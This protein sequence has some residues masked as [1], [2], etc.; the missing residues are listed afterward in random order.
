MDNSYLNNVISQVVLYIRVKWTPTH[1]S[2]LGSSRVTVTMDNT[3]LERQ[4]GTG[5]HSS[6]TDGWDALIRIFHLVLIY[7]LTS[8]ARRTYLGRVGRSG[9][10]KSS[11]TIPREKAILDSFCNY[12]HVKHRCPVILLRG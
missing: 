11:S 3:K 9:S 4:K 5:S 6:V 8:A 12:F 2:A 7:S 10:H 1:Q